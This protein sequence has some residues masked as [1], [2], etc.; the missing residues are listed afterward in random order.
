[1]IALYKDRQ[2]VMVIG[3]AMDFIDPKVVMDFVQS[4]SITYPTVMGNRQIAS[5]LDDISLLPSTY[6]FDPDGKPAARQLGIISRESIER[7]IGSK[8][9][10]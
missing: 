4:M 9:V 2:D 8:S 3:V 1:L 10:K 6:F 5:Q 7:F